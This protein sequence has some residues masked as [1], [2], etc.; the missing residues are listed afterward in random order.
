MKITIAK[1]AILATVT[2]LGSAPAGAIVNAPVPVNAYITYGGLDWAWA[3]PCAPTPDDTCGGFDL[4]YQATQGWR[5][6]TAADFTNAPTAMDFIFDGA[7]VPLNGVS[8]EGTTFDG[9][10]GDGACAAAYFDTFQNHCDYSDGDQGYIYNNP[11]NPGTSAF[12][13]TWVVRDAA[14]PGVP[15]PS[16]WAMLL[17]GFCLTGAAFRRARSGVLAAV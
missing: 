3:S 17:A 4:T 15:E 2:A 5:V 12:D 1:L 6:A 8:T 16:S 14:A 11:N 7:N 9:A 13:E 10:P